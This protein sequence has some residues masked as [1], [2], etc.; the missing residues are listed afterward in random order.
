MHNIVVTEASGSEAVP[1]GSNVSN[2]TV[3][4]CAN[5]ILLITWHKTLNACC[6][7]NIVLCLLLVFYRHTQSYRPHDFFRHFNKYI[8]TY[9]CY[10][11]KL[12]QPSTPKLSNPTIPNICK[13][14]IRKLTECACMHGNS[15][16][17]CSMGT[18]HDTTC[19]NDI[20]QLYTSS[21][22][23]L[24]RT[25]HFTLDLH[26]NSGLQCFDTVRWASGRAPGM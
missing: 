25:L 11:K 18:Q 6:Q 22:L 12:R 3:P 15:T 17:A 10:L 13:S 19:G 26:Y 24:P 2:V 16:T 21:N 14:V 20:H 1:Y 9:I 23:H 7:E 5:T 4:V 8:P